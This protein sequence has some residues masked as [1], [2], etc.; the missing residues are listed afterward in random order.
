MGFSL[1]SMTFVFIIFLS[2][3]DIFT[4]VNGSDLSMNP[5]FNFLAPI[6]LIASIPG[7]FSGSPCF[8]NYSYTI[9]CNKDSK[10]LNESMKSYRL[11]YFYFWCFCINCF[12]RNRFLLSPLNLH[13]RMSTSCFSIIIPQ[14]YILA[15]P[16]SR[17]FK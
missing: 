11:F 8:R 9:T 13:E 15:E 7:Y 1:S 4:S 17:F 3:L 16:F 14:F 5:D 2:P 6:M 12:S 10:K